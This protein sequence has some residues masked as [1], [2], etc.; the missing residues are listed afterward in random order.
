[1]SVVNESGLYNLVLGSRKPED[2]RFKRWFTHDNGLRPAVRIVDIDQE[3]VGW[4]FLCRAILI[5]R[6]FDLGKP[7]CRTSDWLQHHCPPVA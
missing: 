1:M 7:T 5:R 3:P 6:L 4:V 2:K